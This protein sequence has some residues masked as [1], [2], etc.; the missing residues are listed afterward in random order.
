[1]NAVHMSSST[2]FL[3][4]FYES[5]PL[6][7][8]IGLIALIAIGLISASFTLILS[9]SEILMGLGTVVC[10]TSVMT[11]FSIC[12]MTK[13]CIH[14]YKKI[15]LKN[16]PRKGSVYEKLDEF[17]AANKTLWRVASCSIFVISLMAI[18]LSVGVTVAGIVSNG[19]F[20]FA[21]FSTIPNFGWLATQSYKKYKKISSDDKIYSETI[22]TAAYAIAVLSFLSSFF[23]FT[24]SVVRLFM[25]LVKTKQTIK[26]LMIG[27]LSIWQASY[28]YV[29]FEKWSATSQIQGSPLH[30]N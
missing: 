28:A 23:A 26:Y 11:F 4:R 16:L 29:K 12:W 1:M 15:C 2:L 24:E 19:Y 6:I 30:T 25:G 27:Y 10:I 3:N 7:F 14:K 17:C 13:Q 20:N 9:V 8:K 18:S 21:L 22:K 5:F